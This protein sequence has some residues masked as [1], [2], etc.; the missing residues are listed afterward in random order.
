MTDSKLASALRQVQAELAQHEAVEEQL[1]ILVDTLEKALGDR[2]NEMAAYNQKL[3]LENHTR[4]QDQREIRALRE[5]L[6]RREEAYANLSKELEALTYGISHDLRA[7]LR[8]LVGFSGA[9]LEDY[10][11]SLDDT[12]RGYLDCMLRAGEKMEGQ[13]EALVKLSR[14]TNQRLTVKTVDLGKLVRDHA[15]ILVRQAPDRQAVLTIPEGISVNADHELMATAINNLVDN[16]WKFTVRKET[17]LIE[18]GYHRQGDETV[19]YLR[20]NGVGFDMRYAERL[21]GPFQRMHGGSEWQGAG[22]GL[23]LVQR[24][25]HRHGGRI[26]AEAEPGEGATFFFTIADQNAPGGGAY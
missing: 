26:W 7:P 15:D 24:V 13:I 16:A 25:I 9:L 2:Q 8:H 5:R 3:R 10:A 23:A 11:G 18:F 1:Y 22:V 17:A 12:A 21:F 14:V 20:D 19:Y 4:V 6:V